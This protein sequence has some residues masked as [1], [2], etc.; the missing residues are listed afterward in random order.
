MWKR[1][2]PDL[3]TGALGLA[4]FAWAFRSYFRAD[5]SVAL[6]PDNEYLLQP[7]FHELSRA[8]HS[9]EQP[10]WTPTLF[11]GMPLYDTPQFSITYPFYFLWANLYDGPVATQLWSHRVAVL[12][13]F[14]LY[15]NGYVLGRV[16]A[17]RPVAALGVGVVLAM[18]GEAFQYSMALNFLASIAWLPLVLAGAWLVLEQRHATA[19]V[20]LGA[21]AWALMALATPSHDFLHSIYLVAALWLARGVIWA[22]APRSATP[23]RQPFVQKTAQLAL[24]G[25]IA[26]LLASPMVLPALLHAPEMIRFI[27]DAAPVRADAQLPLA[28]CA[29]GQLA[30]R[31][32]WSAVV[33]LELQSVLGH[34]YVGAPAIALAL[35]ALTDTRRRALVVPLFAFGLYMLLSSTGS[36]LGLLHLNHALPLLG[37]IREPSR[38]LIAFVMCAAVLAGAARARPPCHGRSRCM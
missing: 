22:R 21:L 24:T 15:V 31:A 9:G 19:G 34:P 37:K 12:H 2:G 26:G 30:P 4:L 27:G 16:L 23:L 5:R 10:Y 25:A 29:V 6:F 18:S 20:I 17:L 33:P 11:G 35:L 13:L 14:I 7:L 36:H 3:L 8:L 32:L 38:H 28:A 1:L